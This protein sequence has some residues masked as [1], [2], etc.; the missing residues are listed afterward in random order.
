MLVNPSVCIYKSWF[1]VA[2]FICLHAI[3][4]L[5]YNP[6]KNIVYSHFNDF[7]KWENTGQLPIVL[8]KTFQLQMQIGTP[9]SSLKYLDWERE[10][11][12]MQML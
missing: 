12:K 8:N 11:L 6:V 4:F 2:S 3:Y 10:F 5:K 1:D 9:W 7:W